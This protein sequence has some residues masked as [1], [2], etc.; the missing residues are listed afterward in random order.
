MPI[1]K[2][3]LEFW[4]KCEETVD[5][6][7]TDVI[8]YYIDNNQSLNTIKINI[9]KISDE[10]RL[11]FYVQNELLE[12][13]FYYTDPDG[14]LQDSGSEQQY[15]N[16][17]ENDLNGSLYNWFHVSLQWT[18]TKSIIFIN[19]N[20]INNKNHNMSSLDQKGIF[21][22]GYE[23]NIDSN[24]KQKFKLAEC[25]LF[26]KT[27]TQNEIYANMNN[28]LKFPWKNN[29]YLVGYWPLNGIFND[30]SKNSVGFSVSSNKNNYFSER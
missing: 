23:N 14:N 3:S 10:L 21:K 11:R 12:W 1:D 7:E 18:T 9:Q 25:K 24:N 30:F 20:E 5:T 15:I 4:I 13:F 22:L 6:N 26:T 27:F 8:H 28:E 2:F 19:G 16:V 29:P 17:K